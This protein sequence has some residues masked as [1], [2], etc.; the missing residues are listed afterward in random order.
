MADWP[1]YR[2]RMLVKMRDRGMSASE[3]AKAMGTTRNAIIGKMDRMGMMRRKRGPNLPAK[4]EDFVRA[5][6]PSPPRKFSWQ[7]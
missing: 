1:D 7:Q 2:E 4:A 3:I 6:P 5:R